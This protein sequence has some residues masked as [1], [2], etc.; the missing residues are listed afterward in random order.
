MPFIMQYVRRLILQ[1]GVTNSASWR[2]NRSV[3]MNKG[4]L[5]SLNVPLLTSNVHFISKM[6]PSI[7]LFMF[8]FTLLLPQ[9]FTELKKV[10]FSR[11]GYA[12]SFDA[13]G[14]PVPTYE[15]VNWQRNKMG[16]TE[17]VTVG[18][19]DASLPAGVV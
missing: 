13:N 16:I 11:N 15:L 10:N 14:D 1:L 8:C 5:M 7:A 4:I 12:V 6:G 19:Y 2:L 18:L 17:L 3:R 9:V